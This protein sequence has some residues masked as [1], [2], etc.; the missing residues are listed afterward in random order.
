MTSKHL[1]TK[2]S[3]AWIFI[4]LS[5]LV[6]RVQANEAAA[7]VLFTHGVVTLTTATG[8]HDLVKG[9]D[10]PAGSTINTADNSRA[11]LR[12]TDGGLVSLMPNTTFSVDS[13][14]QPSADDEGSISMNLVKGGLRSLSGSI[15][16]KNQESYELKTKVATLGIRGTQYVATY[17]GNVMRVHVG[18]GSVA[19]TNEFGELVLNPGQSAEVFEGQAP[20]PTQVQPQIASTATDSASS[21]DP[22]DSDGDKW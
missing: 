12:F 19:L 8:S 20:K 5:L 11:Q 15:G 16:K 9:N 1:F 10:V 17:E 4:A 14:S 3:L 7:T 18:D 21:D 22:N 6:F 13:Y 2:A